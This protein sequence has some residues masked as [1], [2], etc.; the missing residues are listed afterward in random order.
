MSA[1]QGV[2]EKDATSSVWLND[3]LAHEGGGHVTPLDG[4]LRADICIVGGGYTGLWTALELKARDPGLD[5]VVL[6]KDLCGSGG[7]GANAGYALSIWLQ[8]PLLARLYGT[9]EALRLCRASDEDLSAIG[10]FSRDHDIDTQ[11]DRQGAIWGATCEAQSGHWEPM[12]ESLERH[13]VHHFKRVDGDEIAAMTGT[14]AHVAGVLDQSAATIQPAMLAR[15]LRRVAIEQGIRIF[16]KSPMI[17]LKRDS[18]PAVVTPRGTVTAD[19]VILALYAWSL[20]VR[21]LRSS[22][23]VICTDAAMTAPVPG[24]LDDL[25]WRDGPALMDSR[26]FVEAYRTTRNGQVMW[27]KSGGAMPYGAR[28]DPC[29]KSIS[30][31]LGFLRDVLRA[32]YPGLA[33]Q[34]VAGTWAGPIDRTRDGLPMF[35]ALAAAPDIL[36]GYGYSGAGIVFSK[37]GSRILAS[38]A[39]ETDDAWSQGGLVRP[40]PGGFPPE[41]LRYVGAHMVRAAIARKDRFDHEGRDVGPITRGLLKFKPHSYKPT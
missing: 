9:E 4:S 39:L 17:R 25:G 11:F 31:P 38:L 34:T 7:S 33:D 37:L 28:L 24:A 15:G 41:P 32:P 22:I 2:V 23:M 6:E 40:V 16:E 36:Y 19:K 8:F 14:T 5:I 12:L 3:A 30:R 20:G 27:T 29:L 26:T 18:P 21:E 10:S 35:G 13:Q 1:S